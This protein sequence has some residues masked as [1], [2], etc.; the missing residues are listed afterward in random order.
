MT[1]DWIRQLPC[2]LLLL[3][4]APPLQAA[5]PTAPAGSYRYVINDEGRGDIGTMTIT[6]GQ[7]G[8]A[9]E[10]AV[11]RRI[12][13]KVL[14]ITVY[15]N[16]SR[17]EQR[18]DAGRLT[19]LSRVTDDNGDKSE[20]QIAREGDKLVASAGGRQW[21]LDPALLSTSPWTKAVVTRDRLIDTNSGRAVQVT[22]ESKGKRRVEAGGETVEAEGFAQRGDLK[23]DLW[24]D[25]RGRLVELVIYR[26]GN[27]VTVTL[28]EG[29]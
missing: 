27:T 23:R 20:L 7:S 28:T 9:T 1:T 11:E 3:L 26:D 18:L 12:Q 22:N 17:V 2:V 24:Y 19:K 25:T 4:L 16:S 14:G 29:P 21:D 8:G 6:V 10:V 15:R 13:V 5:E